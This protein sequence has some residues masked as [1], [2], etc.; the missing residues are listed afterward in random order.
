MRV[1]SGYLLER[2]ECG[3]SMR[4]ASEDAGSQEEVIVTSHI[5]CEGECAYMYKRTILDTT[6]FKVVMVMNLSELYS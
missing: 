2:Q 4:V 5:T 3:D 1:A 6:S